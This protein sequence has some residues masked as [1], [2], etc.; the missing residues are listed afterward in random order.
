MLLVRRYLAWPLVVPL[1]VLG[2]LAGHWLAYRL[3]VPDAHVR[4]HV[5]AVS[6]H[7][8]MAYAPA[9][10]GV[11]AALIALGFVAV[12]FHEAR[13]GRAGTEAP[14][15]LVALLPPLAF[16]AQEYLERYIQQG[17][18][19]WGVALAA[20]VR[21]RP[22]TSGA[23]RAARSGR[24]GPARARCPSGG[25]QPGS[26]TI[27]ACRA[28]AQGFHNPSCRRRTARADSRAWLRRPSSSPRSLVA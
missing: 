1:S 7:G 8:Y 13:G 21:G 14:A 25:R 5:L 27:A 18:V 26:P 15:W 20:D 3:V 19:E 22:R 24:R 10:V 6:G 17:S 11:S 9:A 23:V 4:S 16:V 28:R 12:V 2:V